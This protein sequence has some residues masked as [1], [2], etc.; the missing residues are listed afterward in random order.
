[1]GIRLTG[2]GYG[3]AVVAAGAL[4]L[5]ACGGDSSPSQAEINAARK[6][7]A[8][9]QK[10]QD[11]I[12]DLQEQLKDQK[13]NDGQSSGSSNS[14]GGSSG[15]TSFSG[16]DC[17]NGVVAGPNTSCPFALNVAS[18]FHSSGGATQITVYSP[19]TGET[20]SMSCTP[21]QPNI[22]RGGNN[23]SVAFP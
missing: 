14:S 5:A 9:Q 2:I 12:K 22:C 7:A 8:L 21:G 6:E 18:E 1:M 16:S 15:S 19:V 11:Q 17:G 4:L 23:A 3:F 10:Q 13:E 20:Y